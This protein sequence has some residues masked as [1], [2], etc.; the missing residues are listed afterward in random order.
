M[1]MIQRFFIITNEQKDPGLVFTKRVEEYLNIKG[2]RCY[3]AVSEKQRTRMRQVLDA[4][5]DCVLVLGGDGT[6]IR[7]ARET[8]SCGVPLMGI[9]LGTMGYLAEAETTTWKEALDQL[10]DDNYMIEKRMML[11]GRVSDEK[12]NVLYRSNPD[13]ALNDIVIG[14]SGG[15]ALRILSFNVYINGQLLNTIEADALIISTPTGS[16]AYNM[17]AGGP[18]I[19]PKAELITITPVCPHTLNTRSTILAPDDK[20]TIELSYS[21]HGQGQEAEVYFDGAICV[22]M[23]TGD[24]IDISRSDKA[25]RLIKLSEKSFME[26]LKKKMSF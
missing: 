25:T 22:L 19:E 1:A 14:R 9:N 26:T 11:E 15:S 4:E 20:V 5:T 21:M 18:I 6:V 8:I 24:R 16:T 13:Y 17:S 7:A 23:H 2:K 10:I 3:M 12:G